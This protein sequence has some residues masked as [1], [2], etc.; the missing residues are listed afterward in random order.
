MANGRLALGLLAAGGYGLLS[1]LLMLHAADRPWAVA[2][3]LG[4]VL[5]MGLG[6]ALRRRH[7][8]SLAALVL[9][10][11]GLAAIVAGGGI[12][13]VQRLYVLQHVGVHAAL[14]LS[15]GATLLGGRPSLIGR[16]AERLHG[17]LSP[18]MARY[19]R[20][21]TQLWTGYFAAAVVLSLWVYACCPWS[22]WS[23]L[24]NVI[25]P[26]AIVTL[27]VGEYLLRYRLHPEFERAALADMVRAYRDAPE[28]AARAR[29]G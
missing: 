28:P 11:V 4:P 20:A 13:Q 1:H 6:I 26:V 19:T 21:V 29:G 12:G 14:G 10:V 24:A 9:A 18:A 15:F 23:L 16:L 25:T 5:L 22:W 3:L 8:P 27:F 7:G 2:A 17:P